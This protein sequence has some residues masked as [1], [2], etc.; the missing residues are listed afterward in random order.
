MARVAKIFVLSAACVVGSSALPPLASA[1]QDAEKGCPS[2]TPSDYDELNARLLLRLA[3]APAAHSL[4]TLVCDESGAR[5]EWEGRR[6]ELP[7][8]ERL[9]DEV[10]EV[11]EAMLDADAAPSAPA[12]ARRP[13]IAEEPAPDRTSAP[14][15]RARPAPPANR[16]AIALGLETE[17]PSHEIGTTLG[18]VFEEGVNLSALTLGAREAFR[19]ALT[20]PQVSFMD[21]EALLAFGAPLRQSEPLGFAARLG[22]ECLVAHPR[23]VLS[24]AAAPLAGL[25]LRAARDFE[26]VG[27]W[28]GVDARLRLTPLRAGEGEPIRAS[29][30]TTS[31]S[32]GVTFLDSPRDAKRK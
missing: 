27:I 5:V 14:A 29:D 24:V 22:V 20:D 10:L 26:A 25:G 2:L 32:F 18:P 9:V 7:N 23:G 19:F 13:S 6:A 12:P 4:P 8:R 3:T 17:L 16:G 21:F 28:L 31:F 11:V 30:V 1:S 15:P